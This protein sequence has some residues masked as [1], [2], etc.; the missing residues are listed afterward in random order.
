MRRSG[1]SGG[2]LHDR[3]QAVVTIDQDGGGVT[4]VKAQQRPVRAI[5]IETQEGNRVVDEVLRQK[6]GTIDLP[7]PPF[8]PPMR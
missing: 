2:G 3:V 1:C 7:T 5:G 4:G 8:S 6:A